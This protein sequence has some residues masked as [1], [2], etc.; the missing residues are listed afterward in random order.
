MAAGYTSASGRTN[1]ASSTVI[2]CL[3]LIYFDR[4]E[5]KVKKVFCFTRH[6]EK[7]VTG[8]GIMPEADLFIIVLHIPI[9]ST[10]WFGFFCNKPVRSDNSV[11]YMSN[12]QR[13]AP[14]ALN[15]VKGTL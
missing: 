4:R 2:S 13:A 14:N 10:G 15:A 8:C 6:C 12:W 9:R 11:F 1:A 7:L 3:R 5:A